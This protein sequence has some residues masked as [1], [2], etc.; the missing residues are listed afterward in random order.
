[1]CR[2]RVHKK[3]GVGLQQGLYAFTKSFLRLKCMFYISHLVS[4][5][6][7]F[8][9]GFVNAS[10]P[11]WRFLM[12]TV[13]WWQV[14]IVNAS[15]CASWLAS[16]KWTKAYLPNVSFVMRSNHALHT[17][18]FYTT[19]R[20]HSHIVITITILCIHPIVNDVYSSLSSPYHR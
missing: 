17:S 10:R 15:W 6:V 12:V 8:P 20:T 19:K 7:L 3:T 9:K 5:E 16:N 2:F 1:M 13:W 14:H 18:S 11:C 4:H